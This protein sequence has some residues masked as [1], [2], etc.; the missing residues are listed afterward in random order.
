M[1][2]PSSPP[3]P[4]KPE[5]L[6]PPRAA[7]PLARAATRLAFRAAAAA[8]IS[9]RRAASSAASCRSPAARREICSPSSRPLMKSAAYRTP[10]ALR[11]RSRHSLR[12]RG[13]RA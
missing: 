6:R 4:S 7:V 3:S 9:S 10:D 1:L 13:V 8:R 11:S 2:S 12:G 5:A